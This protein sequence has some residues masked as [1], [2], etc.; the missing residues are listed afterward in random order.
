MLTEKEG[1]QF[2]RKGPKDKTQIWTVK[3]TYLRS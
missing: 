2:R 3:Q 1:G